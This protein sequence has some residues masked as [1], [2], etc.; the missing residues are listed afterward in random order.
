MLMPSVVTV[1]VMS[2]GIA[3]ATMPRNNLAALLAA[4]YF[5]KL[6]SAI[7]EYGA[8]RPLTARAAPLLVGQPERGRHH[9]DAR[10]RR[11]LV[12]V[13]MRGQRR[14]AASL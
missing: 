2:G 14:R 9:K 3:L 12:C 7:R 8:W 5:L 13:S 11:G 6:Y 4:Y 10:A 1:V